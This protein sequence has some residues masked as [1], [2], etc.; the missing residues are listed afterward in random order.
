MRKAHWVNK[1]TTNNRLYNIS[2]FQKDD[3]CCWGCV[4]RYRRG[5]YYIYDDDHRFG[6]SYPSWKLVSK[7]K[8]QWETKKLV[9]KR[10][11]NGYDIRW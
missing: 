1:T 10:N 4:N 11:R 5:Y 2:I 7:N 3:L 8:K 9:F 6:S